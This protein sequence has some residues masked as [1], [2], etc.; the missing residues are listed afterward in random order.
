MVTA[1]DMRVVGDRFVLQSEVFFDTARADLL[2]EGRLELDK[3]AGALVELEKQIPQDIAW[4]LRVDGH[5][6]VRPTL[7]A[8]AFD[9][10]GSLRRARHRGG[11]VSDRARA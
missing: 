3:V 8:A 2:P 9:E 7:Q 4:V 5:T 6:D 11:A 10:L 1:P